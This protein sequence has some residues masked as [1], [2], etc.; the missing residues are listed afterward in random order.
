M[1]HRPIWQAHST[2]ILPFPRMACMVI[3]RPIRVTF[4]LMSGICLL[5]VRPC[6]IYSRWL[7]VLLLEI[8]TCGSH[9]IKTHQYTLRT[10]RRQKR[11]QHVRVR[12]SDINRCI[13]NKISHPPLKHSFSRLRPRCRAPMALVAQFLY[14]GAQPLC[15]PVATDPCTPWPLPSIRTAQ[16]R[17][18]LPLHNSGMQSQSNQHRNRKRQLTLCHTIAHL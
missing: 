16:P 15:P 8:L 9:L 5:Q 6:P 3:N 14:N 2:H 7:R 11:R 17:S 1:L 4:A 12:I 13:A 18:W 10:S